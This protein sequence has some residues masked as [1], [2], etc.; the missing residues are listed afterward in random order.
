MDTMKTPATTPG[1]RGSLE[2][3]FHDLSV[4]PLL[5]KAEERELALRRIAGDPQARQRLIEC[6]LRLVI[7]I[8]RRLT[9]LG[10]SLED[11]IAEGNQGLMKAVDRFDPAAGASLSTYA[12]WWIRQAIHRA[13]E[14]HGRTVRLPS[15]VLMEARQLRNAASELAQSLGREP[16]DEELAGHLRVSG[17]R[18]ASLRAAS[19]P[20]LPLDAPTPD[21]RELHETLADDEGGSADPYQV[22]CQG[23]DSQRVESIL[24]KLPPR[25]R[26]I[27]EARFGL[28]GCMPITLSDLGKKLGVTRERVRQLES[29]AMALLRQALLRLNAPVRADISPMPLPENVVPLPAA[30]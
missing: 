14:N 21:G 23:C 2:R 25:L 7:S 19:Q 3:Y 29:R 5:T 13:I 26:T 12:T 27:I 8:A 1:Q 22:A 6:N 16:D 4:L 9:G 30:A 17:K 11:L 24:A 15:H 20:M 18:V 10:L 28:G